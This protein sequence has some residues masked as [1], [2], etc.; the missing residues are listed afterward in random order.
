MKLQIGLS[1]LIT[2]IPVHVRDMLNLLQKHPDLHKL[3]ADGLF[4]VAKTHNTFPLIGFDQN[5]E[6]LNK[7][8]KMNGGTLNLSDDCIFTEWPV[9]GTEIALVITEFEAGMQTRKE[10]LTPSPLIRVEVSKEDLQQK[11]RHLLQHF[12]KQEI[13]FLMT[14]MKSSSSIPKK[15]CQR[16]LLKALC[17]HEEGNK[18][19]SVFV[20]EHQESHIVAFHEA[21]K[22]K[23]IFL[24][25]NQPQTKRRKHVVR[26][27]TACNGRR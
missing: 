6:Q 14:A 25:S 10:T 23:E 4:T 11:P 1:F 22:T 19:H 20:M 18:Q 27:R 3:F 12:K 15:S 17:S 2:I 9:A 7:E 26:A 24:P 5:H 13:P 21:I 8:L 16:K